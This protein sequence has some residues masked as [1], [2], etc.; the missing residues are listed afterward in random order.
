MKIFAQ[1]YDFN[2]QLKFNLKYG[3]EKVATVANGYD[4]VQ[5]ALRGEKV[6]DGEEGD[7][8]ISYLD[9][10]G[11]SDAFTQID[12]LNE[13]GETLLKYKKLSEEK[14]K[15]YGSMYFKLAVLGGILVAVLLA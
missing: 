6:V 4:C 7:F 9:G 15:K 13:K 1:F 10:I 12:Y 5:K 3:R 11:S 8:L 14:Y 2:E